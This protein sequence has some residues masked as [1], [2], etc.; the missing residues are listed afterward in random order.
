MHAELVAYWIRTSALLAAPI[1]PHYA[2]HI[3]S[4]ILGSS[5][6]VQRALWP[7]P[8]KAVD[9]PTVEAGAYMRE[10][11]KTIRDAELAMLKKMGKGK[12]PQVSFDPK[13]PK[14]VRVYVATKFPEWQ[15]IC[16]GAV[17]ESWDAEKEKVD[18]VK[19]RS[20]LT[21]KGLIKE[22]RAMPFVQLFK[23]CPCD[24]YQFRTH[25][26]LT[27]LVVETHRGLRRGDCVQAW[28]ALL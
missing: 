7:T 1:A 24:I 25:C 9:K 4:T 14:A 16:V 12:G 13:K 15:D 11:V 19:V 28:P 10:I 18:D 20:I 17:K 3:Y 8:E 2:E 27:L 23:V 22:K 5:T 26:D 21:E 6:S